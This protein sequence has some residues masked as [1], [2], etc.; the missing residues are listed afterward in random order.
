MDPYR[1][2]EKAPDAPGQLYN[3][4]ID[5]GE[6]NNL[7]HDFPEIVMELKSKLEEFK[8]SGRSAPTRE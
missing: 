4:Q 8:T 2:P 7:Y 1:L 6:T 5:P 3:L